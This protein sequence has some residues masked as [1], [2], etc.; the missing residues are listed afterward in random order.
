MAG[1]CFFGGV[2]QSIVSGNF[3]ELKLL[4]IV[5]VLLKKMKKETKKINIIILSFHK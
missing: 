3:I 2:S 4:N 1:E 5:G